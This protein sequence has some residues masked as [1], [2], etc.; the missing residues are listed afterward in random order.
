ME[1]PEAELPGFGAPGVEEEAAE[2]TAPD[3]VTPPSPVSVP[4]PPGWH[5]ATAS[6]AE[7]TAT[8]TA[9]P[10]IPFTYRMLSPESLLSGARLL[11]ALVEPDRTVESGVLPHSDL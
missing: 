7:A 2:L 6:A 10:R 3:G 5:P 11:T 8:A 9:E 4:L 1:E